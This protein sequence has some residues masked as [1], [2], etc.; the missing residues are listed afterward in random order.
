MISQKTSR[1]IGLGASILSQGYVIY[2]CALTTCGCRVAFQSVPEG[3]AATNNITAW[4][5]YEYRVDVRNGGHAELSDE[6]RV[7]TTNAAV[8][9]RRSGITNE[10]LVTSE[11]RQRLFRRLLQADIRELPVAFL[12]G[13]PQRCIAAHV[14]GQSM[15]WAV[16][17]AKREDNPPTSRHF[18]D[19][20]DKSH[21]ILME[22]VTNVVIVRL[23]E[24]NLSARD[25]TGTEHQKQGLPA[26]PLVGRP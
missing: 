25:K 11:E 10:V 7:S 15:L 2:F 5:Y 3:T 23:S 12:S 16:N 13:R 9:Y 6:L 4:V 24:A 26:A 19:I 1:R 21:H 8:M 20:V 22:F 17:H 18:Y 14:N